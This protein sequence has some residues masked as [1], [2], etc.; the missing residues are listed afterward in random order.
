M[1]IPNIRKNSS[2]YRAKEDFPITFANSE[3]ASLELSN[4]KIRK[5][6]ECRSRN[7]VVKRKV[8]PTLKCIYRM[9]RIIR[10]TARAF[11]PSDA[12]KDK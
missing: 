6:L 4:L 7:K 2:K 3:R 8:E 12:T 10:S 1:I 11:P 9:R 5:I